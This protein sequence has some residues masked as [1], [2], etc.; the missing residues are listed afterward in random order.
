MKIEVSF[1]AK[2]DFSVMLR[3]VF[4]GSNGTTCKKR[5]ETGFFMVVHVKATTELMVLKQSTLLFSNKSSNVSAAQHS[6]HC[7]YETKP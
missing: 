4:E 1:R 7:T 6:L 5:I 2:F 3:D